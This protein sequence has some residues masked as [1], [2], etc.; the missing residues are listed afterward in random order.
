MKERTYSWLKSGPTAG[1]RADL[2]LVKE[3][4]QRERADPQWVKERIYGW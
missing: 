2:Q 3:Q 1:E 4:P